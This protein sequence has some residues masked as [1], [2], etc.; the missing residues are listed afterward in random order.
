MPEPLD[1]TR[2]D[3]VTCKYHGPGRGDDS[4]PPEAQ[5]VYGYLS[6]EL[7]VAIGKRLRI[8]LSRIYGVA[9]L[10]AQFYTTPRGRYTVRVCRGPPVTF[11]EE[12]E[13]SSR[14]SSDI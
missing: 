10:Y 12:K 14:P 6:E 1:L 3:E 13:C 5:E 9:S 8:P 11:G 2:I 4:H 7:L